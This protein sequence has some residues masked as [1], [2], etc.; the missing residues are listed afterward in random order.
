[1]GIN[2]ISM[3]VFQGNKNIE[4]PKKLDPK[5][6]NGSFK[7]YPKKILQRTSIKRLP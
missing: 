1:M 6:I 2:S 3:I 4:E 7:K 5:P